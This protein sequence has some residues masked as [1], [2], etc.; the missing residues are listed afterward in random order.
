[1]EA[2]RQEYEDV[3]TSLPINHSQAEL[4]MFTS[5]SKRP[6]ASDIDLPRAIRLHSLVVQFASLRY[7]SKR[8]TWLERQFSA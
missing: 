2:G 1:M 7:V 3:L 4:P 6:V 8:W 5:Q